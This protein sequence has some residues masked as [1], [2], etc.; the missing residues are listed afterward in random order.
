[1]APSNKTASA[2]SVMIPADLSI[3]EFRR[4]VC[5]AAIKGSHGTIFAFSTRVGVS[6][7]AVSAVLNGHWRSARIETALAH[8]TGI[9]MQVL[10]PSQEKAA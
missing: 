6:R 4:R 1:M 10:F 5:L 8:L 7:Q 3:K 2:L 9:P